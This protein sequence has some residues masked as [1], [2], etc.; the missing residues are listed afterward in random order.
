MIQLSGQTM[1][2]CSRLLKRKGC[3]SYFVDNQGGI[4][5]DIG[6]LRNGFKYKYNFS[7]IGCP[8]SQGWAEE[9]ENPAIFSGSTGNFPGGSGWKTPFFPGSTGKSEGDYSGYPVL[10]ECHLLFRQILA[11]KRVRISKYF[12]FRRSSHNSKIFYFIGTPYS[13]RFI[14]FFKV[15]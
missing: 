13:R 5:Q 6:C 2:S 10:V 9:P 7:R 12:S 1:E 4:D 3:C 8:V 14:Y 15:I 11:T